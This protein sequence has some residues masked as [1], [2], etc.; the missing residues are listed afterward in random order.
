MMDR[1][2]TW[3]LGGFVSLL[4]S[5]GLGAVLGMGTTRA[6]PIRPSPVPLDEGEED[7]A[8]VRARNEVQMLDT[9]YKTAVISVTERFP[10]G[11]PAIMVAGDVFEAMEKSGH[12]SARLVDAT[13]SPLGEGNEPA[14][15]F[16]KRAAE[17][18]RKGEA[19]L[20]QIV[21][22]G[23]DRRLLAATVVPAVH[24]RCAACHG[25]EEG[26]LLGFI[27]YDIPIR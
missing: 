17:A 4:G 21:G 9:L 13:E 15:D 1:R 18:M 20:D 24:R 8:V 10:R 12:H 22:E 14:T 7:P 11:Q 26:D 25:V 2:R 27:R 5:V 23:E 16:E 3:I 6:E 19:Y